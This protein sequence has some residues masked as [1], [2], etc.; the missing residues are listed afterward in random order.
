VIESGA[1]SVVGNDSKKTKEIVFIDDGIN[2][3]KPQES[4]KRSAENTITAAIE[5]DVI[6][7]EE[8]VNRIVFLIQDRLNR[9][10]YAN[11]ELQ[12]DGQLGPRTSE[13]IAIYQRANGLQIDGK[14][15]L[16]LLHGIE[17]RVPDPT[18]TAALKD[19]AA[20]AQ[21][22]SS[23]R[24]QLGAFKISENVPKY[25]RTLQEKHNDLLNGLEHQIEQVDGGE[26][27]ILTVLFAGPL[28]DL[29]SA[30]AL[31]RS[32]SEQKVDCLAAQF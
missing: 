27:G 11:P 23:F 10:G 9:L 15:S 6:E 14:A 31:C 26:K 2:V 16:D 18:Q 24:V 12:L 30:N 4:F 13:T 28:P 21:S 8:R 22:R 25:W 19:P 29:S 3:S 7:T 32:L 17:G 20:N 5:S 1:R